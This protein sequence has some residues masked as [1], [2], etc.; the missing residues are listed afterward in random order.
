MLLKTFTAS[1]DI[2]SNI[3][4][5]KFLSPTVLFLFSADTSIDIELDQQPHQSRL[6]EPQSRMTLP[7]P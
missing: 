1:Q 5:Y 4:Y 2:D 6:Q 7:L 3:I